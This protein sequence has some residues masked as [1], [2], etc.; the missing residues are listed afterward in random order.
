MTSSRSKVNVVLLGSGGH[1]RSVV[2]L[3]QACH[4]DVDGVY[5]VSYKKGTKELICGVPLSGVDPPLEK[6]IVLAIG[7]NHKRREAFEK[8]SNRILQPN[9]IH[10]SSLLEKNSVI[11]NSNLVF[12]NVLI[13]CETTIGNNNII[14]SGCIIEHEAQVGDHNHISVGAILCGRVKIGSN[15][16]I[17]AGAV[18]IDSVKICDNVTVGAGSV[19]IRDITEAGTYAGN[20]ARKIK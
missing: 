20:P 4:K 13:N 10:P 5:D 8:Y 3:L 1:S 19:V 18:V 17:G 16:F 15:C 7:D 11:G 6:K 2:C 9:V 12:A 14:N